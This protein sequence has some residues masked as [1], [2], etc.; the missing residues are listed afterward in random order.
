M[1]LFVTVAT[2]NAFIVPNTARPCFSKKEKSLVQWE[3]ECKF[4]SHAVLLPLHLG[5]HSSR[6]LG[7]GPSGRKL[8]FLCP[9]V[10]NQRNACAAVIGPDSVRIF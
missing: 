1:L 5:P 7:S 6:S 10:C 2:V 4:V 8:L 3:R 9:H